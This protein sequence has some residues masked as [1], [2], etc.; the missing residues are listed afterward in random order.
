MLRAP[1]GGAGLQKASAFHF[2][3]PP[4]EDP[5]RNGERQALVKFDYRRRLT[6]A[7]CHFAIRARE[8]LPPAEAS[9][10]LYGSA[11]ETAPPIRADA[12]RAAP[13]ARS[14]LHRPPTPAPAPGLVSPASHAPWPP[15]LFPETGAW[16]LGRA[17]SGSAG[18]FCFSASYS[19]PTFR[20]EIF[21]LLFSFRAS[22]L[23]SP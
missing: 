9:A 2:P 3:F 21:Y 19:A 17:A 15:S 20:S 12:F 22:L 13:S 16:E 7:K 4:S 6:I 23:S 18:T 1:A 8:Y 14:A 11:P 5:F 10:P